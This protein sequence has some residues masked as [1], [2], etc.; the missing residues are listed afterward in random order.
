MSTGMKHASR[1]LKG[2]WLAE[3]HRKGV[4][5]LGRLDRLK[6]CSEVTDAGSEV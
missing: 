2:S 3:T 4:F 6:E 5:S 1:R